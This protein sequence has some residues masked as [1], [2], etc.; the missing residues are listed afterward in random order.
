MFKYLCL[1]TQDNATV[2]S[3]ATTQ[4]YHCCYLFLR[5]YIALK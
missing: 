3:S 5:L 2:E 1:P 4:I